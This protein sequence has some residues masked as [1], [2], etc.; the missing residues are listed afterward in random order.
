MPVDTDTSRELLTYLGAPIDSIRQR[1]RTIELAWLL[2]YRAWTAY[3]PQGGMVQLLDGS[4]HYTIPHARR[5]IERNVARRT[6]ILTPE[7]PWFQTMPLDDTSHEQAEAVQALLAF[8]YNA[9][10]QT[11]R[12]V[13]SLCRCLQL[14]NFA[15]LQSYIRIGPDGVWPQQKAIDP[16]SFYVFPDTAYNVD[17]A[18][19]LFE[20][21]IIP[22]VVYDSYVDR[23]NPDRSI[24][25]PLDGADLSMPMWPYHLIERLSYKGLTSPDAMLA[26]SGRSEER[27]YA[28][29]RRDVSE[30]L[31]RQGTA[32]VSL[33]KVSFKRGREWYFCVICNNCRDGPCVVRFEEIPQEPLYRWCNTRPI[34][35]ELYTTGEMDDIRVLQS[36]CNTA[37]SQV[38]SNR[39]HLA[40]PPVAM[41]VSQ[42]GR[43]ENYTFGNRQIWKTDGDPN[44]IFKSIDVGDTTAMGIRSWQ[45]Y[46]GLLNSVAGGGQL[47]EGEPGRNMPRAGG[48]FGSMLNLQLVDS[49]HAAGIEEDELLTPGLTDVYSL[50]V[51]ATPPSQIFRI[52]GRAGQA[53]QTLSLADVTGQ[54]SFVWQGSL[55][56]ES[57]QERAQKLMTFMGLILQPNV[58]P[59]LVQQLA[60]N[61]QAIDFLGLMRDVYTNGLGE[62]GLSA[63][64]RPM[65]QM[66]QQMFQRQTQM[67]QT[68]QES[69]A[70][71]MQNQVQMT[72]AR[73]GDIASRARERQAKAGL[74]VVRSRREQQQSQIEARSAGVQDQLA[75]AKEQREAQGQQME[76]QGQ[77]MDQ[78]MKLAQMFG[79]GEGGGGGGEETPPPPGA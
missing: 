49:E 12:T 47:A 20:D 46:Y 7:T 54:Y 5:A 63:L 57:N 48:A 13:S 19:I 41:D 34:P 25:E 22:L 18:S 76:A 78:A 29:A 37:M 39:A 3:S 77:Q 53:L 14:Y 68:Q 10:M 26:A 23:D 69:A 28:R 51:Q 70:A 72:R 67:Q 73:V 44:A 31:M 17:E 32:F 43:L 21:V 60:Q 52:P 42:A 33:T 1:R 50:L 65:T 9:K 66:E 38:E 58:L 59:Q 15:V 40:D 35:G 75:I 6:K 2:N 64:I 56:F 8:L 62:R 74:E 61:G 79:E 27:A 71:N 24:L 36:L 30:R 55:G 11:R 45:L 16:F 4:I